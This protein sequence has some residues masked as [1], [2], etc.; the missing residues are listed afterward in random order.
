MATRRTPPKPQPAVRRTIPTAPG[1]PLTLDEARRLARGAA[2]ATR[3]AAKPGRRRGLVAA[4]PEVGVVDLAVERRRRAPARRAERQQRIAEYA[5]LMALLQE[6]GVRKAAPTDRRRAPARA[7]KALARPLRLFAEGDSWFDYPVPFFGGG[8]VKR[9]EELL[10][11]PV[12]N[13]AD[14]GDEVRFMLG[15]EQRKLLAQQLKRGSPAGG[16]WDALMFS[17]GGND[18][19]ADPMALW[20]RDYDAELPA[21][22]HIH[23]QR[24][25]AALGIVVAGYEDLIAL[26]DALSPSTHLVFHTYDWAIPD[27]RGVC[28][29][30]PWLKPTF[31]LRGFPPDL[32]FRGEVVRAML[33]QFATVLKG[34]ARPGSVTVIDGQGTLAPRATSWHNELHPS[35]DGYDTF[36]RIFRDTLEG[37]FPDR[38]P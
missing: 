25:G 15:V 38:L 37:L 12:L 8:V 28:H 6:H 18:I 24:F 7:R 14:A 30:G 27:G 17:G 33:R 5:A 29:L 11:V 9:L 20:I 16:P 1:G 10:G 26:R 4:A 32:A 34:L 13:L 31:D 21:G 23:A 22:E 2:P 35:K 36:A 3:R 19:V